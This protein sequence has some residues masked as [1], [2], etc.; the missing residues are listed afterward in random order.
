METVSTHGEDGQGV[1]DALQGVV[2]EASELLKSAGRNGG[3]QMESLRKRLESQLRRA[4]IELAAFHESAT[5]NAKR[6]ARATDE[7]V[8]EHPYAA[9][10]VAAGVGVLLGMLIA[11]R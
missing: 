8:H 7:A 5:D 3:E 4:R 2:N 6:A 9:M 11:R 10:G 1:A